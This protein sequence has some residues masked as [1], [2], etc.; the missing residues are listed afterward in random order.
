MHIHCVLE[1]FKLEPM[2]IQSRL[3][4]LPL[5]PLP[6]VV[7]SRFSTSV[8]TELYPTTIHACF[9]R[10]RM[11]ACTRT[12]HEVHDVQLGGATKRRKYF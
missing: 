10:M 9:G 7:Q 5:N 8:H 3:N 2:H 1:Y 4:P 6:E 11:R 12:L